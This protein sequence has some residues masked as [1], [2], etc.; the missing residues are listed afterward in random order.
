MDPLLVRAVQGDA[1]R[2]NFK[3]GR[4]HQLMRKYGLQGASVVASEHGL[5]L[6]RKISA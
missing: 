6:P 2:I 5:Q 3:P 1:G 4:K